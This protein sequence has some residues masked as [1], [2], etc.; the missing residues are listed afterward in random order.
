[1]TILTVLCFSSPMAAAKKPLKAAGDK[2]T[3]PDQ[4]IRHA[5]KNL[6]GCVE[7]EDKKLTD[8][9]HSLYE[10]CLFDKL[11][12]PKPPGLP[13]RW[14]S[15]SGANDSAYGKCQLQWDTMFILNAWACLRHSQAIISGSR[16][17]ETSRW[18]TEW[19]P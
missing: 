15:I 13:Y 5:R 8:L 4:T 3:H 14:F 18:T 11:W 10:K 12:E 19:I 7:T 6:P 2:L 9:A 16:T 17:C 1:M